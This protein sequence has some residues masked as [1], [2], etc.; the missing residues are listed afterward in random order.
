MLKQNKL[1]VGGFG[2]NYWW[3]INSRPCT[4]RDIILKVVGSQP[5]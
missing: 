3:L 1:V 4:H 2:P 5:I